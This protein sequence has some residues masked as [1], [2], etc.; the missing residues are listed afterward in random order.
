MDA[1]RAPGPPDSAAAT[2][3][4]ATAAATVA[5]NAI[6]V[7]FITP[8]WSSF[9]TPPAWGGASTDQVGSA[10]SP[11]W[12]DD[13]AR[14]RRSTRRDA[15]DHDLRDEEQKSRG[16]RDEQGHGR[17]AAR[18]GAHRGRHGQRKRQVWK[19]ERKRRRG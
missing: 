7:R 1:C 12:E 18:A 15:P 2:A 11:G 3:G 10:G 16:E 4:T 13:P 5:T 14:P 19:V 9:P 6:S 17:L 8:P